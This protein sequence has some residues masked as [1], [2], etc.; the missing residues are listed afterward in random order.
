MSPH[1]HVGC[2][3]CNCEASGCIQDVYIVCANWVMSSSSWQGDFS[4]SSSA[5]T[6]VTLGVPSQPLSHLSMPRAV[7]GPITAKCSRTL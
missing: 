7:H 5:H 6:E 1:Y 2:E 4:M 3:T